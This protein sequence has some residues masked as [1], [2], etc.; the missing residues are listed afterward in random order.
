MEFCC[1]C[2]TQSVRSECKI[3]IHLRK[4]CVSNEKLRIYMLPTTLANLREQDTVKKHV[5][6]LLVLGNVCIGMHAEHLRVW[7]ER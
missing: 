3:E 7:N 5:S 1:K 4:E 6:L 2:L